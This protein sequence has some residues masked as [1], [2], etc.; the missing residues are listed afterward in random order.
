MIRKYG[1]LIMAL[2]KSIKDI[3]TIKVII[4]GIDNGGKA[5]NYSKRFF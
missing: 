2:K 5:I 3:K 4:G 1:I